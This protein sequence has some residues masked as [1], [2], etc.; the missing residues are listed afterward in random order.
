MDEPQEDKL[1]IT[2]ETTE[3]SVHT[4][5]ELEDGEGLIVETSQEQETG[6]VDYRQ[7]DHLLYYF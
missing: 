4:K 7:I 1:A 5:Q 3:G 6:W 2:I